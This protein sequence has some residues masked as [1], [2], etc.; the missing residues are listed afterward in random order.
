MVKVFVQAFVAALVL[1]SAGAM[2]EIPPVAPAQV[3]VIHDEGGVSIDHLVDGE[4]EP[5][6]AQQSAPSV[7]SSVPIWPVATVNGRPGVLD[8]NPTRAKLPGGPGR[9]VAIVG[10][11]AESRSWLIANAQRLQEMGAAV[12]V[13]NVENEA[14][15]LELRGL[16]DVPIAPGSADSLFD[17]VGVNVWPILI[18]ANGNISQ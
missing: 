7:P 18:D 4:L 8:E 5:E 11:D 1:G 6:G 17:A 10:D 2:A 14:R 3:V 13:A 16:V 12:L 15:F 9:P